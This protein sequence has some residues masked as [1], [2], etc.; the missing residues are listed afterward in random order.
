MMAWRPP[1]TT[2]TTET[3]TEINPRT[4][5][6][7]ERG[8]YTRKLTALEAQ[9]AQQAIANSVANANA[10]Q[11]KVDREQLNRAKLRIVELE[12]QVAAL[13]QELQSLK[14]HSAITVAHAKLEASQTMTAE[15]LAKYQ[16]GL[17]DGARLLAGR[18][19]APSP[20]GDTSATPSSTGRWT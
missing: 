12:H 15:L 2:A 20:F 19:P 8:P 4:G 1:R 7:Y 11:K 10:E 5:L 9:K 16:Q 17:Q 13:K 6:P 18:L 3:I 14:E